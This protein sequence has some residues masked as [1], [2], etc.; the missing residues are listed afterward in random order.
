MGSLVLGLI[1]WEGLGFSSYFLVVFLRTRGGLGGAIQTILTN[2]LGDIGLLCAIG[3][4]VGFET[5]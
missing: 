1:G 4:S 5:N 3:L 2:R